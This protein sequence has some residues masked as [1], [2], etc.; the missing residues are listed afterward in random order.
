MRKIL[1]IIFVPIF[2]L[3][4]QKDEVITPDESGLKPPQQK[5]EIDLIGFAGHD[6]KAIAVNVKELII[7][8]FQL[9]NPAKEST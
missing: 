5:N 9:P 7:Y 8:W 3:G 4:C 1:F 2:F 6:I